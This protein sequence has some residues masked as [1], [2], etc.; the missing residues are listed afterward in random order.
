MNYWGGEPKLKKI[1]VKVIPDNQTRVMA[2]EKGEI[3]LIFGKN[4]LDVDSIRKFKDNKDFTV[5]LSEATSTRQIVL[6][7]NNSV[8][9]DTNVRKALQHATNKQ[10][11]SD[12]IFYGVEKPADTLFAK[13]IPYC[14]IDLKPYQYDAALAEKML[15]EAG[16][17]K[18]SDGI[19]AK[20]GQKM[21]LGLLYNSD[22]VTEKAI[23]EYL[24][25]EYSKLGIVLNIHGEEEQSYRDKMK[26]GNFDMV[27]NICWGT[28]Y[29]PQSSLAAMRMP[30]YGDFAA[31]QGLADKKEIDA[32]ITE[33]MVSTDEGQR[34]QLYNYVLTRLHDDAVYIPLTYECNKALYRSDLKGMHFMQTQYEVPFQDMYIE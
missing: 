17:V 26:A 1:L 19:R 5:A 33:I 10:A 20:G 11:I 31:Q 18:G 32:A 30:V 29:D 9:A 14:N 15:D 3:D 21:E 27:F 25:S 23:S 28:P 34:Q 13:T 7:T 24:Q 8:L 22:S 2:L 6:N 16:W 12:G 4:M